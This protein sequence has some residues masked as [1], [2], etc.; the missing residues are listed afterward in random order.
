MTFH[1][2]KETKKRNV[3]NFIEY[4]Y[5]LGNEPLGH[6][7][8][9]NRDGFYDNQVNHP[10]NKFGTVI[11]KGMKLVKSFKYFDNNKNRLTDIQNMA[12]QIIQ[13]DKITG[14][15]C[16][17]VHPLDYLSVSENTY[18]W[19][20]CH[21]LDGEY[22]SGNLS[23]M[24]DSSTVI[25][26]IKGADNV[27]LPMFP[28][29]V[30]WNSKKWR[31]L[32]YVSDYWNMVFAG[33]QYPFSSST[34]I[35]EARVRFLTL[36]RKDVSAYC[37][38]TDPVITEVEDHYGHEYDLLDPHIQIRGRLYPLH[39]IVINHPDSLQFNDVLRSSCYRAHYTA[40]RN[41]PWYSEMVDR[42]YVGGTCNCLRCGEGKITNPESFMCDD[43][44]LEYGEIDSEVY[45]TCDCCG[46]RMLREEAYYIYDTE[47]ICESCANSECFVCACCDEL[48][49]NIDKVYIEAED[50]YVCTN[51]YRRE[52]DFEN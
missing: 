29:D 7:L 18:N 28:E 38:W 32:F 17:S 35:E 52:Y 3:D 16:F 37:S 40:N 26:Y 1:L 11:P 12:S 8:E 42:V 2:D 25:C 30:K 43:C 22:R 34:G 36:M 45:G 6:F 10:Y 13:Q 19:H 9:L 5:D 49:Y 20:S 4:V 46:R 48:Y 23:Y 51:C 39:D 44:E 15:L 50:K 31:V 47:E 27:K 41:V 33:R 14:T 21:A 24:V